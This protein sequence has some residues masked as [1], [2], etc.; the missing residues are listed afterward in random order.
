VCQQLGCS[1]NSGVIVKQS[2]ASHITDIAA[3]VGKQ[4]ITDNTVIAY[5]L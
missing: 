3:D 2:A 4:N 5:D 1:K